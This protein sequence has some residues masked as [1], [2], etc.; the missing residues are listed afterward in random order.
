MQNLEPHTHAKNIF[1]S[2]C[3]ILP[4][5]RNYRSSQVEKL[6]ENKTRKELSHQDINLEKNPEKKW[7]KQKKTGRV[8]SKPKLL[9]YRLDG[10]LH[11]DINRS[12]L[13]R[14]VDLGRKVVSHIS[15][16]IDRILH[17]YW[18]VWGHRDSHGGTQWCCLREEG[19]VPKREFELNGLLHRHRNFFLFRAHGRLG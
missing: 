4:H 10:N 16:R 7:K 3:T 11:L 9:R 2:T 17:H 18:I 8:Q 12:L 5:G 6:T 1:F 13:F 15:E 14:V 19:Q